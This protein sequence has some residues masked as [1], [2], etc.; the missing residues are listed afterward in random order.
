LTVIGD[1]AAPRPPRQ[2]LPR[3]GRYASAMLSA[4]AVHVRARLGGRA[5][6]PVL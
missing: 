1:Q 6:R 5:R 4:E 3:P 2:D